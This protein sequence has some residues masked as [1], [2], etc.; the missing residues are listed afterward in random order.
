MVRELRLL[1][2][3]SQEQLAERANSSPKH[4]GR[5]ERGQVNVGLDGLAAL[6]RA[7][8]VNIGDLFAEPPGRQTPRSVVHVISGD[9]VAH[10]EKI[11]A[12]ARRL[13]SPRARRSRGSAR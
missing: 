11:A 13:T 4:V 1:R 9:E 8:S 5:I 6:A 12:L 3:W 7:L 10:L 2:G